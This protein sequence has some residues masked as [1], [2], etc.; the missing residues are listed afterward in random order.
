MTKHLPSI[1]KDKDRLEILLLKQIIYTFLDN[2]GSIVY[3]N[4]V[5]VTHDDK[6]RLVIARQDDFRVG[7]TFAKE[8]ILSLVDTLVNPL[9]SEDTFNANDFAFYNSKY[10]S[11]TAVPWSA[12]KRGY[13]IEALLM[14]EGKFPAKLTK[15]EA[16]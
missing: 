9:Y 13:T 2:E 15:I 1:I 8:H 10:A 7:S 11:G 16:E 3:Q 5:F 14:G 4:R 6:Q 12:I